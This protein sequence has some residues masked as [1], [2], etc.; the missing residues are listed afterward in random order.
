MSA[1]G[2]VSITAGSTLEEFGHVGDALRPIVGDGDEERADVQLDVVESA[3]GSGRFGHDRHVR[4]HLFG[5]HRRQRFVTDH[6]GVQRAVDPDDVGFAS[7]DRQ[8]PLAATA[9][10]DRRA[11]R[12]HGLG[13][14]VVVGDGVVVAGEGERSGAHDAL[15]HGE[16]LDEAVDA[17]TGAVVLHPGLLVVRGHP[18]GAEADL[19]PPV[20]QHVH[21]RQF[22][23]EHERMLVVVVEHQ[24]TGAQGGGGVEDGLQRGHRGELLVEVVRHRRRPSSRATRPDVPAPSNPLHRER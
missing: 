3:G 10:E 24:R 9:D 15:D 13:E 4:G 6:T 5:R 17:H 14:A 1:N 22:L 18:A 19:D 8:H 11:R 2:I 16:A 7:G 20:G 23:G 21:R 12:L